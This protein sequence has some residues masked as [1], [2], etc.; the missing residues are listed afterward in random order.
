MRS[1]TTFKHAA[2]TTG[3]YLLLVVVALLV[4]YPIWTAINISFLT[5]KE[6]GSFPPH[7]VPSHF[8]F[9][10]YIRA[11]RQAPL[12]RYLLNSV[13]QSG[14][15]MSGQL[16]TAC[17]AAYA[18]SMLEFKGKR[19]LFLAFLFVLDCSPQLIVKSGYGH[20]FAKH[21]IDSLIEN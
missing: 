7:L 19:V 21:E 16:F 15:V 12:I 18:F 2:K 20:I 3:A 5:D 17:L 14:I 10:N 9:Q 6:V 8:Q 4:I 13:I 11:F 1:K